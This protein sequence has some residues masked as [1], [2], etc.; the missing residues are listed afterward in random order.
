MQKNEQKK[1]GCKK[2]EKGTKN[3]KKEEGTKK[4]KNFSFLE[5]FLLYNKLDFFF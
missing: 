2:N 5:N 4:G 1:K 3:S